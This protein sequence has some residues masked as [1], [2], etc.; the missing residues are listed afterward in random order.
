[1]DRSGQH[2]RALLAVLGPIAA[3]LSLVA[4]ACGGGGDDTAA[5]S[6]TRRGHEGHDLAA[7]S[8][9]GADYHD[10]C[11]LG[12][13]TARFNETTELAHHVD[14]HADVGGADFTLDEWL[15]VFVDEDLGLSGDGVLEEME[16][17]AI[18]RRHI[19]GGVLT[20]T[21]DPDSWVPMTDAAQ[22]EALA[23]ELQASRAVAMRYPTVADAQAAGYQQGDRY[24][25]GLGVHYQR[26]DLLGAFDPER[27][28]QL[29][30]DGT[31]PDDG[32]V[33]LSYV[34]QQAGGVAPEGFTGS[35]DRWH[36][37][38]KFCLDLDACNVNL[39]SDVLSPEE[40]AA[41]GG[42]HVPNTDGWMLH[43]WVVPG[44]ESDWGMFSGANRRLPYIPAN[45]SFASGCNSGKPVTDRLDLDD[46]GH[47]PRLT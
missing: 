6:D 34:V 39:S 12:F 31:A 14:H 35:N 22:C 21:L 26:W 5:S 7:L 2:P 46:R 37:H 25:A 44:C 16:P 18:Y 4:A 8:G 43:V 13:N 3:A 42:T 33:G 20:H 32:L 23:G 9:A 38:R 40:C 45:G 17:D 41:I 29:L 10:R 47:G 11:D 36:R 15:D 1:M 28:V 27:P 30:Y 24:F 19:L